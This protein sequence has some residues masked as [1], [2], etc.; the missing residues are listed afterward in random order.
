MRITTIQFFIQ[1]NACASLKTIKPNDSGGIEMTSA[2]RYSFGYR[3]GSV[4]SL[5]IVINWPF[6]LTVLQI[7][8]I[9]ISD[10]RYDGF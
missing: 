9:G 4:M 6:S 2:A 5:S 1:A 10:D 8:I 7:I 3:S